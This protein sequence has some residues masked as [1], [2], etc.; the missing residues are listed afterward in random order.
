[1][2]R[3]PRIGPLGIPQNIIQLVNNRQVCFACEK[4]V[5]SDPTY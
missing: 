1:M 5:S 2:S 4:K 3:L